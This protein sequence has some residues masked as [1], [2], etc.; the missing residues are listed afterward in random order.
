MVLLLH[1]LATSLVYVFTG[2]LL[3]WLPEARLAPRCPDKASDTWRC[4]LR[5]PPLRKPSR[6]CRCLFPATTDRCFPGCCC[7]CGGE[8]NNNGAPVKGLHE[9]I[10]DSLGGFVSRRFQNSMK[11]MFK[12][13]WKNCEKVLS[14]SS[15]IQRHVRTVHLG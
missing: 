13:L 3:Q 6:F 12:C 7:C 5:R 15:G 4:R 1:S 2:L 9:G 10:C 14:T 11:V 8:I